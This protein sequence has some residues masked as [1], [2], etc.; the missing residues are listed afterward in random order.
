MVHKILTSAR[1]TRVSTRQRGRRARHGADIHPRRHRRPPGPGRGRRPPRPARLLDR[2][3]ARHGGAGGARAGARGARQLRLRLPAAADRRQPGAGQPAQGRARAWT[4]RSPR[5]CWPPPGSSSGSA[6]RGWRWS[7]S[8]RWT[9]RCG[10]SPGVLAI[11]E[12]ARERGAEARGRAG[13]ERRRGGA[14]RGHRGDR[15]GAAS[16]SC[17]RWPPASG[18][19]SAPSRCRCCSTPPAGAPDLADLRGQPPPALRARGRRG[20]RSQPADDR[21][22]GGRQVARG[23]PPAL[24]PAAAGAGGGARGGADRQRLRAARAAASA[25]AGRSARRITRSARRAWSAAATRPGP[26][27]AT[28]AHR[29]VLFLD[30]LCEFRRDTL[31]ALRAPLESGCGR[32]RPRRRQPAPAL[33]LHAGRRG[34]PVPLRARRGRLRS[35]AARRSRCG[36]TRAGS[37]A[38]SP[39]GIDILA[40]IRQPSA[41]E[42]GGAPGEPSA[43]VRER[44]GRGPRAAGRPPRRRAAATPR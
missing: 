32:D 8:W 27:E 10:R 29:G 43:A 11:A 19:P 22:A 16:T 44:V 37:A 13:R 9:A 28:L 42:I 17:R 31:E 2:R 6:C 18:C 4:C 1:H 23:E 34:Q 7:A 26:G 41:A 21:P 36:A 38:R 14:G 30:E 40:A 3:P 15:R 25:A 33:S 5:R 12:A 20:G 35:A 39:T 24:D